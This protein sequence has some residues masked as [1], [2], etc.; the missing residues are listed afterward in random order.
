MGR[1][2]TT[3]NLGK[4]NLSRPIAKDPGMNDSHHIGCFFIIEVSSAGNPISSYCSI[5]PET[6]C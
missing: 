3:I 1:Y 6:G 5:L 4:S 2:S